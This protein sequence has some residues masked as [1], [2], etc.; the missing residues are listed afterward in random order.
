MGLNFLWWITSMWAASQQTDRKKK[1]VI[2]KDILKPPLAFKM[3]LHWHSSMWADLNVK[4]MRGNDTHRQ[5]HLHAHTHT[6]RHAHHKGNEGPRACVCEHTIQLIY[7]LSNNQLQS[8][9]SN[10]TFFCRPLNLCV[11]KWIICGDILFSTTHKGTSVFLFSLRQNVQ[12]GNKL[13]S[14]LM[15]KDSYNLWTYKHKQ[16]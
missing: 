5:M 1:S 2:D 13:S 10:V 16:W 12:K 14:P 3:L 11:T 15:Y 9:E 8:V 4:Q 7:G 6:R